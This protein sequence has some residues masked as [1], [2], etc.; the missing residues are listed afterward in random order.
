MT[1]WVKY[2]NSMIVSICDDVLTNTIDSNSSKAIKLSFTISITSQPETVL[3]VLIEYLD[4]VVGRIRYDDR[5]VWSDC[6]TSR[7]C[8]KSG[9]APP[10]TEF[11]YQ[12]LFLEVLTLRHTTYTCGARGL[13]KCRSGGACRV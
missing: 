9:L 3:A 7:P 10:S 4:A 2:L 11:Q 12:G 1:T 5:V 8:K 6:Y 13:L